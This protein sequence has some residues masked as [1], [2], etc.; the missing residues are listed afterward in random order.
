MFRIAVSSLPGCSLPALAAVLW[1]KKEKRKERLGPR[2]KS[3][4]KEIHPHYNLSVKVLKARHIHGADML[5]DADC[6]VQLQLPTA[7]PVPSRTKVVYNSSDPEW[8]ETFHYRIHGAIKNILELTLYDRDVVMDD[9]L[10][11]IVF[12]VGNIKPGQTKTEVFKL[13][14]KDKGVL[15]V[16]FHLEESQEPPAEIITNGVLVAH[17]CVCVEGRITNGQKGK[18]GNQIVKLSVPGS[19]EKQICALLKQAQTNEAGIP[20]VFHAD[21]DFNPSLNVC[22]EQTLQVGQN[23][24]A[25]E[26]DK[27]TVYLGKG[28]LPI[29]ALPDGTEINLSIPLS[30]EHIINMSMTKEESSPQE[31]DIRLGFGLSDGERDFLE[32]RKKVV[33]K[34]VKEVLELDKVSGSR[35]VPVVAV[36]G[37]GGGTRAMTSFY[38]SLLGLQE[39][40]LLDSITYLS[41]VSGSTWC[42]CTLYEDSN[43]S[44]KDLQGPVSKTRSSVTS[45]KAGAFSTDRLM[46]CTKALV[47][48]EKEGHK[49]NFSDLWGLVLEYFLHQ[50]DNPAKL[51]DQKECVERGQNPY[52]I[53][54][55]VNVRVNISG[56]DFAEWC[57]FTPHEIGI[58]K[59]GAFIRTEDFGSEFFMGHLI[60][61]RTEPKICYLQ[62]VWGS[63]FAANLDEIWARAAGTGILWLNSLT[64]VIRVMDDCRKL[65]WDPSRLQTR[66]VMP[67]GIVSNIFQEFFKSRFTAGE[68]CN[69]TRGLYLYKEYKG[70]REFLAWKGNHLDAFPNQLTPMEENLYLVDGGF[71][72]N[73]PFPLVLQPERDVDV[74]LSFNYSWQA[75]F[76]VL[77]L[78]KKYCRER[79]IEFP[80]ITVSEKDEQQPKECYVFMDE[81]NP[82]SPIV[83][84]FPLV[85][86]TFRTYKEPGLLRETESE[87]AYGDFKLV[88]KDSPYRTKNFTYEPN[89]FERL[90]EVNRYNVI[91]NKEQIMKAL[92]AALDRRKHKI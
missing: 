71:S 1:W 18:K 10:F 80:S 37:S 66:L 70:V 43:W 62:G 59:Y 31:L 7:S 55:G 5:S 86:D 44:Q 12:D 60:N 52:P 24:L 34:S 58:R 65:R 73:S 46:H 38:G 9:K 53:Y 8:Q 49:V 77:H 40:K 23:D 15:E 36:L 26:L 21:R 83:I 47:A 11:S 32:K 29:S 41:G 85:N 48:M 90:V 74:I 50:A 69:F 20:F 2:P 30:K 84:H 63:A 35:E 39:L 25:P 28:S 3:W 45:T 19:Y 6:Y 88:G 92:R 87:M 22:L 78:T 67:G 56:G 13:S 33:A 51:S 42:M 72:I 82:H 68:R 14:P 54:A 4:R 75:P 89:D 76:E 57:E 27:Q 91:N 79:G 81:D 17:P 61:R 64:D 16:E